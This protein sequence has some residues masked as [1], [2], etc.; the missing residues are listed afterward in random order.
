MFAYIPN[1]MSTESILYCITVNC[2]ET[3]NTGSVNKSAEVSKQKQ[4]DSSF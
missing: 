4:F 3:K 2:L 1:S